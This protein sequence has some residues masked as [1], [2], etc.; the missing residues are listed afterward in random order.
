VKFIFQPAEEG[1]PTGEECGARLMIKEGVLSKPAPEVIFGLHTVP[2][3][4]GIVGYRAGGILAGA[5]TFRITIEGKQTHGAVPW[6]GV[7]PVVVA[8]QIVLALQLIPSR[9]LNSSHSPTIISIGSIHAGVRANIIPASAEM[10]GTI[11]I[12]D[13]KIRE[14]VLQRIRRTAVKI[15]ESSGAQAIVTITPYA[16][17]TYNDPELTA[18]MLPTLRRIAGR[19]LIETPPLT[20]SED[21]SFFQELIPGLYFLLGVNAKGVAAGEAA[22]NHS[23]YYYINEDAL[24]LGVQALSSLVVDYLNASR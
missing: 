7:D 1:P 14:D 2:L 16:P 9:Q 5:D 20:P 11:R 22:A 3:P 17:V 13:P 10:Q 24:P 19:G 12:L 6:A 15:A 18:K 23:P 21:F 8:A 4:T